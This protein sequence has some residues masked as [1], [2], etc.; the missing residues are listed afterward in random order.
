MVGDSQCLP[1]II[2]INSLLNRK[3]HKLSFKC[4]GN[5]RR[6]TNPPLMNLWRPLLWVCMSINLRSK[7]WSCSAALHW[8]IWASS[9]T[10][11]WSKNPIALLRLN[12]VPSCKKN[13]IHWVSFT[14]SKFIARQ[15]NLWC[16]VGHH[17]E[18]QY[19]YVWNQWE[20]YSYKLKRLHNYHLLVTV[21]FD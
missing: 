13:E 6:E 19:I 4:C 16:S 9:L 18:T 7:L 15:V 11:D 17:A 12:S 5:S 3:L 21:S 2:C 20:D 1:Q 8:P 10:F 14:S